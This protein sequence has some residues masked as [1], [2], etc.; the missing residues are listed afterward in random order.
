VMPYIMQAVDNRIVN[1]SYALGGQKYG[2]DWS[3]S[4]RMASKSFFLSLVTCLV[5]PIVMMMLYFRVTRNMLLYFAPK[6]GNGPS[7]DILQNGYFNFNFWAKG[8]N[9]DT[10]QPC[11]FRAGLSAKNG[12]PGYAQTAKFVAEAGIC[13]ALDTQKIPQ[14]YGMLTP[15]ISMGAVLRQRLQN[16]E[17][18]FFVL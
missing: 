3:Y 17:V 2:P 1:R 6:P 15:S 5:S 12:D 10:K 11:L 9:N 14:R 18:D 4:E 8:I 16:K 7:Q 13:L